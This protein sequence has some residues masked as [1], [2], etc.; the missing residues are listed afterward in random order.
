LLNT[1]H[2]PARKNIHM[3]RSAKDKLGLKIADLYCIPCK[4]GEVYVGQTGR[5][6]ETRSKEHVRYICLNHPEKSAMVENSF[7][8]G[9][10]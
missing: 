9:H 5:T 3:L 1:I 10:S 4:C 8:A 6:I 2:I 7:K